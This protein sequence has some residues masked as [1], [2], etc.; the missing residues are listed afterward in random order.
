MIGFLRD[1]GECWCSV[2]I[3]IGRGWGTM[4]NP[5]VAL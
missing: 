3:M 2:R 1:D 4:S 5:M